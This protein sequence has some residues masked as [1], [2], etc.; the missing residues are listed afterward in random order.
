MISE[1]RLKVLEKIKEYE[2]Q[3]LWD[4][5]VE[6]DPETI[7]LEPD[8]V[9]YLGEKVSSKIKTYFSNRLAVAFYERQ[10]RK[11]NFIIKDI[12]GLENFKAVKGGAIL[13]CNHFHPF[14]NYAV[15]R[16]IRKD[17]DGK[18]L[19]K[20]IREGNYTNFKGLYGVLFRNCNTLP[21]SS[22][23]QTMRKFLSSVKA[24]LSRGEKILIYPEQ[25]MWWNYRKPRPM[26]NGA[27][28]MASSNNVP[29]IPVF[30]TMEDT[31]R[32]DGDGCKIQAYT[33]NFLPAIYPNENL[34]VK[35]NTQIMNDKNYSAWKEIYEK[36]YS[37]PLTYGE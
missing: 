20:I 22:N 34:S 4:K 16:A 32:L 8:K 23:M 14:D 1:Y 24:L 10:I 31:D 27:F 25:G 30:I 18:M 11:K 33:I 6:D 17:M 37:T 9:D 28:N 2:K 36:F 12:V 13:T 21:L 7:V 29:I 35:E 15:W 3:G 5:D 19:Y 26:K